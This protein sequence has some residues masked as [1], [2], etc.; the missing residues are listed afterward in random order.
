[1]G[2]IDPFF[3]L[4]LNFREINKDVLSLAQLWS[5]IASRALWV[6]QLRS[7]DKLTTAIALITLCIVV[8]AHWANSSDVPVSEESVALRAE[9]LVD[10]LLKRIVSLVDTLKYVLSNL[11]VFWGRSAAESVKVAVEPLVDLL[12]DFEVL[13]T[14]LA[15]GL[16]L[17]LGLCFSSCT[18]LVGAAYI[19]R[20]VSGK[21][22]VACKHI[23]GKNAT[24]NV[25][26]VWYVVDVRQC[27]SYQ[28]V[29]FALNRTLLGQ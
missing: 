19:N 27:T 29:A 13:I 23:T 28:D 21:S 5:R 11:S 4:G 7:V 15:R 20:V 6:N 1:M 25:A 3:K 22:A 8:A 24:D 26:E 14:N 17:L 16:A 18:V 10:H 12:V 9:E 2:L